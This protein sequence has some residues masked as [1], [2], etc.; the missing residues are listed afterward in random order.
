MI[1]TSITYALLVFL[2]A[3][4]ACTES[5]RNYADA[6]CVLQVVSNRARSGWGRYDG[7]LMDALMEKHQHAHGCRWPITEEHLVLGARFVAGTLDPE[8][9]CRE[10]MFYCSPMYDIP[11]DCQEKRGEEV[12]R[13]AHIYYS[14]GRRPSVARR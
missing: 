1:I 6:E 8:P 4:V 10:A 13:I 3:D 11:A 2:A 12:G 9:F 5:S 14:G 7:T